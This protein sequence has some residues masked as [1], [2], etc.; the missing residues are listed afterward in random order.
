M[1]NRAGYFEDSFTHAATA[2]SASFQAS[3][4]VADKRFAYLVTSDVDI[5]LHRTEAPAG[6]A[7]AATT[8]DMFVPAKMPFLVD[9]FAGDWLSWVKHT[10]AS[11]GN[12]W[13]TR[14]DH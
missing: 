1:T 2:V 7:T 5:H 11:N 8:A 13:I 3:A 10:G 4:S 12:I 14:V 6:S 9:L